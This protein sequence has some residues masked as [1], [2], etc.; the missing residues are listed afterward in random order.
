MHLVVNNAKYSILE[1]TLSIV[2]TNLIFLLVGN[3]ISTS[4]FYETQNIILKR[5]HINYI[6]KKFSLLESL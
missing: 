3:N 5:S 2:S 1:Q 6:I 4:L